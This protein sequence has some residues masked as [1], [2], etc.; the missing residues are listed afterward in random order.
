MSETEN[1]YSTNPH[2]LSARR[3]IKIELFVCLVLVLLAPLVAVLAFFEVCLPS[4]ESSAIWFQR[5]GSIVTVFAVIIDARLAGLLRYTSESGLQTSLDEA[6]RKGLKLPVQLV[7]IVALIITV[8]G[9]L[10][11]GYG[12]LWV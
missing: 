9:T 2:V 7:G 3:S 11:W 5:S 1:P 4:G 8:L 10:I 6:I 12:D